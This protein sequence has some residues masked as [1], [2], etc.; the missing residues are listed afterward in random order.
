MHHCH[1]V[2]IA[3]DKSA[4]LDLPFLIQSN[5]RAILPLATA[6]P[7]GE[8]NRRLPD[9]PVSPIPFIAPGIDASFQSPASDSCRPARCESARLW[10]FVAVRKKGS[11]ATP[12]VSSLCPIFESTRKH[13]SSFQ[14][15]RI[16]LQS[17]R[18]AFASKKWP[19][20]C[21]RHH[22][23][24]S[25]AASVVRPPGTEHGGPAARCRGL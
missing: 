1:C 25:V 9:P 2:S 4:S 3:P 11:V 16:T 22:R 21:P 12:S 15:Q 7:D 10:N 17:P 19:A 14:V 5:W 20:Q 23:R 24:Q 18:N 13:F 6:Y 8:R